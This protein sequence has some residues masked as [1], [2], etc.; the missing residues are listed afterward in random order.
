[1]DVRR[2]TPADAAAL[3]KIQQGL[4]MKRIA[5]LLA[6]TLLAAGAAHAQLNE[7]E[8]RI[9][10]AVKQRM[11]AALE[12]LEKSVRINSGTL[13]P[14][15]VRAVGEV[16]RAELQALG[17]HTRW[18]EMPPAM[19]RGGHLIASREGGQGKRVLLM[20]HLDTVF[21]KESTVAAWERRGN[22]VRGQG[23]SD[24]KG[25]NAILIEALRALRSVGALDKAN[26]EVIFTGDEERTGAPLEVARAPMI[27]LRDGR[28]LWPPV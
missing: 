2:L 26:I 24:M 9:V 1:M 11:P 14:E 13:N 10:A 22:R 25:G 15:G 3:Q 16:Y 28:L 7:T 8:Q 27:E 4:P 21:E 12:L 18:A 5:N 17:L 20:G 6:C 19:K 23:V